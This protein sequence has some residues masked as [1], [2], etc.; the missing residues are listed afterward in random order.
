MTVCISN[1][2]SLGRCASLGVGAGPAAAEG[3]EVAMNLWTMSALYVVSVAFS[4]TGA[5]CSALPLSSVGRTDDTMSSFR[6]FL[7]YQSCQS[8][9]YRR[10]LLH[11]SIARHPAPEGE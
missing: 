6:C 2:L 3:C 5:L 4:V 11:D 1:C 7:T 9:I 10:C 8:L